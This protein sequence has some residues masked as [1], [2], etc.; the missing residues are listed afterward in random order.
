[1]KLKTA[2]RLGRVSNLPTVWTNVLVG[3]ALGGASWA[4][5]GDWGR[6]VLVLLAMS[7][8]YVGGMFLN[9]AYDA[10]IDDL[11]SYLMSLRSEP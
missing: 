11:V 7:A 2:L 6:V 4:S 10:E 5:W 3:A 1:M 8:A 9:D